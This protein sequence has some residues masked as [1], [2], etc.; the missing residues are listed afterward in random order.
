MHCLLSGK[1]WSLRQVWDCLYWENQKFSPWWSCLC[2]THTYVCF[3]NRP[4]S[5]YLSSL[6]RTSLCWRLYWRVSLRWTRRQCVP[7]CGPLHRVL[8]VQHGMSTCCG[9]THRFNEESLKVHTFMRSGFS[10]SLYLCLWSWCAG[11]CGRWSKD[12]QANETQSI[13][14]D[15]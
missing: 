4:R 14:R 10:A 3:S 11:C 7:G 12:G 8:Y 9:R 6:W 13:Q 1:V 15:N 2:S 5:P